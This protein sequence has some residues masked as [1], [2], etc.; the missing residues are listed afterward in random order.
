MTLGER[1]LRGIS[2]SADVSQQRRA[3]ISR[4]IRTWLEISSDFGVYLISFDLLCSNLVELSILC[5]L[6]PRCVPR[7]AAA[8][9]NYFSSPGSVRG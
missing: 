9:Q 1:G 7:T 6:L 2:L 3:L 5:T 8:S 4:W